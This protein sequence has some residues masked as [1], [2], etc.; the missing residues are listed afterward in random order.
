MYVCCLCP[1]AG[2]SMDEGIA[3]QLYT[4]L[5]R[6]ITQKIETTTHT[7]GSEE[8]RGQK[9]TAM[10]HER[11]RRRREGNE[12]G[13]EMDEKERPKTEGHAKD[14]AAKVTEEELDESQGGRER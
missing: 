13:K 3:Q 1:G 12:G 14:Q 10:G 5:T 9:G 7:K 6:T 2:R 4:R 11:K 8:T